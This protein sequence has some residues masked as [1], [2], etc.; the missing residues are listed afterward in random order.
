MQIQFIHSITLFR[1][2]AVGEVFCREAEEDTAYVK[3]RILCDELGEVIGNAVKIGKENSLALGRTSEV[4][5]VDN[6]EDI[7]PIVKVTFLVREGD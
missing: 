4:V 1:D 6:D 3:T 7:I 5:Y 2:L